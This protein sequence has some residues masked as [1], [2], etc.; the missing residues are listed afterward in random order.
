M[1]PRCGNRRVNLIFEPPSVARLA[2]G[3]AVSSAPHTFDRSTHG[4]QTL[5]IELG[6]EMYQPSGTT[7]GLTN[8]AGALAAATIGGSLDL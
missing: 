4:E 1:C 3:S 8:E 7:L 6:A 2:A 5:M